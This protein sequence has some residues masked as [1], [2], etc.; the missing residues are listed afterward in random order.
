MMR[1]ILVVFCVFCVATLISEALGLVVLWSR[2]QLTAETIKDIRDVLTGQDQD[3]FS[4]SEESEKLELSNEVVAR[5]RAFGILSLTSRETELNILEA[6]VN[7][8]AETLIQEQKVFE[9]KKKAFEEQLQSTKQEITSAAAEQAR[10]VLLKL[11]EADAV[12]SLMQLTLDENV[13]LIKEMPAKDIARILGE[14][15]AGANDEQ[16]ERGHQIF[17]AISAGEPLRTVTEQGISSLSSDSGPS[18]E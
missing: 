9:A 8:R 7:T 16:I 6:M 1:S 12:D 15:F 3:Q 13:V 10:G 17:Q 5:E 11:S 4:D 18:V 2:G 14:F